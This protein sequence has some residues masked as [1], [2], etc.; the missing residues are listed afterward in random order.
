M[1]PGR[2]PRGASPTAEADLA[3]SLLCVAPSS[4]LLWCVFLGVLGTT[5]PRAESFRLL[6]PVTDDRGHFL[7]TGAVSKVANRHHEAPQPTATGQSRLWG[8]RVTGCSGALR[9]GC[10]R[11]VPGVADDV[12]GK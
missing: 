2:L 12:R 3:V 5:R 4:A 6:L 10:S 11:G 1:A 8:W 9:H 7:D